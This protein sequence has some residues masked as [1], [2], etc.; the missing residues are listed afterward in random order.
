MLNYYKKYQFFDLI[1]RYCHFQFLYFLYLQQDIFPIRDRD[2]HKVFD[3]LYNNITEE[4]M[5][6]ILSVNETPTQKI[7]TLINVA[8]NN[9]GTDNISIAYWEAFKDAQN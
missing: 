6:R 2:F 5:C 8:N 9:G 3:A 7:E 4:E 1:K